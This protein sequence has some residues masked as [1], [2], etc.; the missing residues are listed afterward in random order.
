MAFRNREEAARRL[1]DNLIR[2]RGRNP[3]VLAVPRRW[4]AS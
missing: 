1:A 2:Y 3:V 4:P